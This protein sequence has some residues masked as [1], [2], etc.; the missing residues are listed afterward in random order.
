MVRK[1]G[2]SFGGLKGRRDVNPTDQF[3]KAERERHK[4]RNRLER[5]HVREISMLRKNP[6]LIREEMI[7]LQSLERSTPGGLNERQKKHMDKLHLMW[8]IVK[9]HIEAEKTARAAK[10]EGFDGQ[11]AE[12]HAE[13]FD[14]ETLQQASRQAETGGQWSAAG[15]MEDSETSQSESDEDA[16]ENLRQRPVIEIAGEEAVRRA[17]EEMQKKTCQQPGAVAAA[18]PSPE[19]LLARM[20]EQREG[21]LSEVIPPPPPLPPIATEAAA[22]GEGAAP[23]AEGG[24]MFPHTI[25]LPPGPPPA[26]LTAAAKAEGTATAARLPGS[27]VLRPPS[28]LPFRIPGLP[29]GMLPPLPGMMCGVLPG[30]MQG[31]LP[32]RPQQSPTFPMRPL[33]GAVRPPAMLVPAPADVRCARPPAP[34]PAG[35]SQAPT[36]APADWPSNASSGMGTGVKPSGVATRS[37]S[38]ASTTPSL[39]VPTTLRIQHKAPTGKKTEARKISSVAHVTGYSTGVDRVPKKQPPAAPDKNVGLAVADNALPSAAAPKDL[40]AAFDDFLKA[41]GE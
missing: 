39:F 32:P 11:T 35:T 18:L 6:R 2:A 41:V 33:S 21:V 1:S 24:V 27:P 7:K 8:D 10:V 26:H 19:E 37:P 30:V 5:R 9:H 28:V 22:A 36:A 23:E 17:A 34:R 38:G 25:P 31:A 16:D 40:D 12:T 3:R 4:K 20:A 15:L 29:M 14:D 13:M